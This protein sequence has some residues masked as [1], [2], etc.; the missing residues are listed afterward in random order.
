MKTNNKGFTLVEVVVVIGIIGILS[1]ISIMQYG[2]IKAKSQ[3][4][5][6][7]SNL[8]VIEDAVISAIIDGREITDFQGPG[9]GSMITQTNFDQTGLSSYISLA[10]L[11]QVPPGITIM[12]SARDAQG[13][14][15]FL[16]DVSVR[17]G[18]GTDRI[19]EELEKMFPRTMSHSGN[20]EWVTV[21]S[22]TLSVKDKDI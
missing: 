4:A 17:G 6:V 5:Q 15:G 13:G 20:F 11:T 22:E 1:S 19:L 16:V 18:S 9:G 8:H 7:S 3:A 21:S 12:V 10:T 14:K 2:H